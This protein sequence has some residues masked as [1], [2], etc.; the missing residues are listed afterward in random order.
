MLALIFGFF[1]GKGT[2]KVPA[3]W[4]KLEYILERGDYESITVVNKEMAEI[5]VKPEV[6]H[7]QGLEE[8]REEGRKLGL[9]EG[10]KE[11]RKEALLEAARKMLSMGL[12]K[13]IVA[14]ATGIDAEEL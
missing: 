9:E 5:K 12:D 13:A 3:D 2:S 8:G 4:A 14:E 11:G 10:R 6:G 7:E 1:G